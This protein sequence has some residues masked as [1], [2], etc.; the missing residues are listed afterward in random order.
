MNVLGFFVSVCVFV[1]GVW[2]KEDTQ[3]HTHAHT[4]TCT[5]TPR[6]QRDE[7]LLP[8]EGERE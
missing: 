4:Y 8:V 7:R 6:Q 1:V 2:R 3:T 5:H